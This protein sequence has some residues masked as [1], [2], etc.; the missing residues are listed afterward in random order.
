MG[1][2]LSNCCFPVKGSETENQKETGD[3]GE[4]NTPPNEKHESLQSE[5]MF[6]LIT[7]VEGIFKDE[8]KG[9]I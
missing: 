4:E 1:Q 7:P 6:Y 9:K 5:D 2:F 3:E 8:I